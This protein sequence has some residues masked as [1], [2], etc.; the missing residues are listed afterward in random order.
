M[1]DPGGRRRRRL[2]AVT[3]AA[4]STIPLAVAAGGSRPAAARGAVVL[5][6][7][8][9]S[10]GRS[11]YETSCATCHGENGLGTADGPSLAGVGAASVDFMLSTGRMPLNQPDQEPVR[12]QPKFSP[13]QIA[14]IVEYL[15]PVVVGGPPISVVDP[16]AGNLSVGS[17]AYLE[18]CAPCHAAGAIGDSVGGGQI[19]PSLGQALATQIGE[20]IR[21]GPGV[22]PKFGPR[23]L[24][25]EDV[26]S[27]A[28]YLAYL[29]SERNPGGFGLDRVGPYTEGFAAVLIGLGLVIVIIRLT[30]TKT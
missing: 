24:S 23:T 18:F 22:M 11:L 16:S 29:H 5:A 14:A 17:R 27:I 6:Q 26:N 19:A 7:A 2:L 20:A 10:E 4:L 9:P 21:T 12:Q 30:G 13:E 3:V 25:D 1:S 15:Q 8:G 28:A